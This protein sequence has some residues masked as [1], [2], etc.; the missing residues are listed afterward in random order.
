VDQTQSL[1]EVPNLYFSYVGHTP[2]LH[3]FFSREL[4][5]RLHGSLLADGREVSRAIPFGVLNDPVHV[6][7]GEGVGDSFEEVLDLSLPSFIVRQSNIYPLGEPP[8]GGFVEVEGP[9]GGPNYQNSCGRGPYPIQLDQ[10]FRFQPPRRLIF[11][12]TG[13]LSQYRVHFVYEDD[14][15]SLDGCQRKEG[16]H[17]LL[18]FPHPLGDQGAGADAE[19]CRPALSRHSLRQHGLPISWRPIKE[20]AFGGS[21]ESHKD[22]RL[23]L[24]VDDVFHQSFFDLREPLDVVPADPWALIDDSLRDHL[25]HGLV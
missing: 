23:Q 10:E 13:S 21:S 12:L 8:E 2:Y 20:D 15:G 1:L 9:V 16:P 7:G 11:S 6:R 25:H 5:D 14:A 19:E 3:H 24:R 17:E 18:A 4:S 22:L